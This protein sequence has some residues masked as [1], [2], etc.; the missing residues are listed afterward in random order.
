M[1]THQNHIE[2]FQINDGHF[3]EI[4]VGVMQ[5]A[6][7]GG[8]IVGHKKC[9]ETTDLQTFDL[10]ANLRKIDEQEAQ[11]HTELSAKKTVAEM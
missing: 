11:L 10:V 3:C 6:F 7:L 8:V 4:C 5:K 1:A 9:L 2:R